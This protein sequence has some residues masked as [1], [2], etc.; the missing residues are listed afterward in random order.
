MNES[1]QKFY[2]FA[3]ENIMPGKETEAEEL[4]RE[5]FERYDAGTYDQSY[6]DEVKPKYLELVQPDRWEGFKTAVSHF[7]EDLVF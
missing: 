2:D 7:M 5:G 3:M 6:F 4:L 1:H